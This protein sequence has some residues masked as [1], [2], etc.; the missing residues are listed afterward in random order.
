MRRCT[1]HL[2]FA[3]VI[4]M[5]GCAT[6][7]SEPLPETVLEGEWDATDANGQ[8]FLLRFNSSGVLVAITSTLRDGTEQT[9]SVIG[10]TSTIEGSSVTI[11]VPHPEEF[12][13]FT[14]T[15]SADENTIDGSL[16]V[17]TEASGVDFGSII[18]TIPR[19]PFVLVRR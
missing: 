16:Q 12:S 14:G 8:Q 17:D 5:A 9:A 2:W 6:T 13:V 15:L 7:P 4:L 18:I 11:R 19:G 1:C 3:P 10:S